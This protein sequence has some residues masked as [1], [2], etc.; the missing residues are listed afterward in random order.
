VR[1]KPTVP[2]PISHR[3][4]CRECKLMSAL[5]FDGLAWTPLFAANLSRRLAPYK[6]VSLISFTHSYGYDFSAD[7]RDPSL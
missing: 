1:E 7:R 3:A 5:K 2:S 4:V 6:L